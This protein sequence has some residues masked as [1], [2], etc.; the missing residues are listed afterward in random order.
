MNES[1]HDKDE[2][3][4]LVERIL[5]APDGDTRA[6]EDL[7]Q[8]HSK[9][10]VANCRYITRSSSDAEDLAQDVFVK[11]YFAIRSF[12]RRSKF[13]TWL[14]RIK[15]NHC[16]NHLKK[17]EGRYFQ[18][19]ED[20]AAADPGALSTEPRVWRRIEAAH[21]R[22]RIEQALDELT[23]TLRIPLILRDMDEMSY[24]EIA[25]LLGVGL[26]AVKM[27]I[28]R[29]RQEFRQHYQGAPQDKAAEV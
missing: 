16:L 4:T 27:R 12:Q 28:K 22:E 1:R 13:R 25:D 3:L 2:D 20:A 23:D 29:A 21:E 17:T 24:Q 8:R 6:F 14:Q 9:N 10:V 26:S 11:A 19:L 7:V 15:V 18:D 5:E